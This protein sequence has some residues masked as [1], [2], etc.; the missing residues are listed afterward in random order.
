V[1]CTLVLCTVDDRAR[2]L[3]EARRVLR[4]DGTLRFSEHVRG[5]GPAGRVHDLVTP[6]WRRVTPGCHPNRRTAGAIAAA[7]F[8]LQ[9]FERGRLM[10]GL[11][12][13]AGVARHA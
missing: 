8:A 5:G 7:G 3:A 1:V 9:R 11:P 4:P 2:A 10:P 6:V 12:L 13:I